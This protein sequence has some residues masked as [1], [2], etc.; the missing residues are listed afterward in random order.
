MICLKGIIPKSEYKSWV[1]YSQGS[2]KT[3]LMARFWADFNLLVTEG[4][5][6]PQT[7][8]QYEIYG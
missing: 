1:G 2:R 5:V 7:D 3:A 4:K 6:L 8:P